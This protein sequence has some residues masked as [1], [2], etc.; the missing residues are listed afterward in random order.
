MDDFAELDALI[1]VELE[2]KETK[3]AA[4]KARDRLRQ[5]RG[6]KE[7]QEADNQRVREWEAKYMW[8][9]VA[10]TAIFTE[11]VCDRC[12][13]YQYLFSGLFRHEQ[14]R[15]QADSQR[16]VKLDAPADETLPKTIMTQEKRVPMCAEC[17]SMDGFEWEQKDDAPEEVDDTPEDDSAGEEGSW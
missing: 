10:T 2:K 15:T 17:C 3:S 13:D 4:E 9:A 16:W 11:Q 6:T 12:G 14:H 5:G 7:E 8:D 1:A